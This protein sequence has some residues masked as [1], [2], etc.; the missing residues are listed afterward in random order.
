LRLK[1][2]LA[3]VIL[4]ICLASIVAIADSDSADSAESGKAR[5]GNQ[6]YPTV[7]DALSASASGDVVIVIDGAS[8]SSDATV[9]AGA[10]LL[11]PYSDGKGDVDLDGTTDN[12][13]NWEDR[14]KVNPRKAGDKFLKN[15][16]KIPSGKTLTVKGVLIVGGIMSEKFTFDYQ[17]HTSADHAKIVCD[18][19]I[20][21]GS[22][23]E[24]RCYGYIRGNG[25]IT[26]Q[27]GSSVYEPFIVTDFIGGDN[28]ANQYDAGQSPFNRYTFSNIESK[29]VMS[30]GSKL[31]GMA[32]L[33]ADSHYN[34]MNMNLVGTEGSSSLIEL[35]SGSKL[36]ITYNPSKNIKG[37]WESN[38]DSDV[39]KT[40]ISIDGGASF[41]RLI[42]KYKD[43][44]ADT[45][46]VHFSIPYNFD[47]VLSNGTYE[48]SSKIRIL[49]GASITLSKGAVMNVN[50]S[51][52]VYDGL[53]DR[54]YKDKYY[55]MPEQLS[56]ALFSTHGSLII[57]GTLNIGDDGQ[58]LGV[59]ESNGTGKVVVSEGQ[60]YYR[61]SE[62]IVKYGTN[63]AA[64]YMSASANMTYR[65][66]SLW[67]Y[68][69][70]GQRAVLE[71][72]NI[73]TLD[74]S[75]T[76]ATSF[77]Y[78]LNG[79]STKVSVN[80][81]YIGTISSMSRIDGKPIDNPGS[82]DVNPPSGDSGGNQP[83][84]PAIE[85]KPTGV[86]LS[87]D[88]ISLKA[89]STMSLT[90]SKQPSGASGK[91]VWT[92]SDSEILSVD[93]GAVT[94]IKAGV[95][96]VT[97]KI[98]GTDFSASC[99]VTVTEE[100][101]PSDPESGDSGL[102]V[103]VDEQG[104][105]LSD[106]L[107]KE[108]EER[109]AADSE[110]VPQIT[111]NASVTETVKLS[112]G[113]LATIADRGGSIEVVLSNAKVSLNS[114][115]LA[116]NSGALSLTVVKGT[117]PAKYADSYNGRPVYDFSI[118]FDGKSTHEL[119]GKVT[120]TLQYQLKGGED[121]S[122]LFVAYLGDELETIPCTYVDGMVVFD[123]DHFSMYAI[124]YDYKEP[125]PERPPEAEENGGG[126][127]PLVYVA[128]AIGAIA[129]IAFAVVRIKH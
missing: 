9:P 99:V 45:S 21:M 104:K 72:G 123:T 54:E 126:V 75:S 89:G 34:K 84:Q 112:D 111:V 71:P 63:S 23:S 79:E 74:G 127:D 87:S 88:S 107:I 68:T 90:A 73:Y 108:I 25:S 29:M 94:A 36:T 44:T 115:V 17:G 113:L 121:P 52:V 22:G 129:I 86:K 46:T 93:N 27:S 110:Y 124:G 4:A 100:S 82:G 6:W 120:V 65:I 51:L 101:E 96:T 43:R 125:V 50:G 64:Q 33:Y 128:A 41:G 38:I 77:T 103:D 20:V 31:I 12:D 59:L 42:L 55:P 67:A 118:A 58:V 19:S 116:A 105:D 7:E 114:D 69:S 5:I 117:L 26:A 119:S 56:S 95:A 78:N 48:V 47:Y 60:N 18:G 83:S 40:C 10:T 91:L 98:E 76:K 62:V 35:K 106:V 57:N 122:K 14:D 13:S 49:P 24:L 11:V 85:I 109:I 97:V 102:E 2:L 32:N 39:G 37:E 30:Y 15:T 1:R 61:M 16:F 66:M 28:M 80:Q 3:F 81:S 8:L 53:K 92:V 70:N